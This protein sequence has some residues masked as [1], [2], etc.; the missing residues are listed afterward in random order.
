[1]KRIITTSIATFVWAA[2]LAGGSSNLWAQA[3]K[4]EESAG[5]DRTALEAYRK[6]KT[7]R[8]STNFVRT[9]EFYLRNNQFVF[10]KLVSE[11]RT[12]LTIEQLDQSNIVVSTYNRREIDARTLRTKRVPEAKY[13]Q[14]LAQYFASRTWDFRNDPDDFIQAIRCY[15]KA[16]QSLVE[17]YGEDFERLKE[18]EQKI[19]RLQEDRKVWVR[20]VESRARL[21]KLE[22][23]A[24]AEKKFKELEDKVNASV[25]QADEAAAEAKN[26]Y[27]GL[28]RAV[29]EAS[30][31][32]SR[33]VEMLEERMSAN[34]RLLNDF[35]YGGYYY[36]R[37]YPPPI[38]DER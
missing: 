26:D 35:L 16:R 32:L 9:A 2:A 24:E 23:E 12:K 6:P 13:Y 36:R 29:S 11:D 3:R 17:T 37:Y 19:S 21:R 25:K 4:N 1:M 27:Q 34:T 10:G 15:E 28:E 5:T 8:P 18:I 7:S 30:R 33:R 14:D 20:E 31:D 22:L 38:P